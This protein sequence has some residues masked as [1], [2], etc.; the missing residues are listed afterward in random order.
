[1][2]KKKHLIIGS[3]AAG[4]SALKQMRR[5][6][7]DDE[8]KLVSMESHLP[9]SPMSLP[10]LVSG[11]RK[12]SDICMA[13]EHFLHKMQAT[14]IRNRGVEK[15]DSRQSRVIYD[16]GESEAYD[17]L[18]VATGSDPVIQPVLKEAG[19]AGFHIMDD[20][21]RVNA[22]GDNSRITILGAGFV[23]MELAV[24]LAEIGHHIRV[25][26][27]RERILRH[28]FDPEMDDLIIKLFA[29]HGIPVELNWG[30]V[31]DVKKEDICF[32]ATFECGKKVVT[33]FILAATGVAPRLSLLNGSSIKVNKGI[34]VDRRMTT[35]VSNIFAAGDVAESRNFLTGENGLSLIWPSAVEQGKIAGS[36][37]MGA[38]AAYNGWLSMN[39]FNFMGH[40]ALS[41][42]QFM[43]LEGDETFSEKDAGQRSYRKLVYRND[44]LVGANF[45]NVDVDGGA[46]QYLIR[47][48]IG[49][50]SYKELLLKNPK[51]GSLWLMT[52]SEME[53]TLSLER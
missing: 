35:N 47:N 48:R 7:S 18:L 33:D 44:N 29:E 19:V 40:M 16:N 32:E 20:Y 6:G 37:M 1:L 11:R 45:F 21:M 3:G 30:E 27:P 41:I 4:L 22:L 51:E 12:K 46:I 8:V 42:G 9:Y 28:Y 24:S 10:Y 34:V 49:I 5:L 39:A 2:P 52:K 17:T 43:A 50:G 31:T 53:T 14:L 15:L 26:A 23:G 38:E 25:I 13:D 36:N